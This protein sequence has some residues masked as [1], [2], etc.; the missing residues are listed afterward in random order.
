[1]EPGERTGGQPDLEVHER[2][3]GQPALD[4]GRAR[5]RGCPATCFVKPDEAIKVGADPK[6]EGQE[7][8]L[9]GPAEML[10]V[11]GTGPLEQFLA[12]NLG[13]R[14]RLPH[15]GHAG[16]LHHPIQILL[17]QFILF[18]DSSH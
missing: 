3:D 16:A 14:K 18:C 2:G 4:A 5:D 10:G 1:M 9:E 6:I 7:Q 12:R 15:L 13:R 17:L 11:I 8:E